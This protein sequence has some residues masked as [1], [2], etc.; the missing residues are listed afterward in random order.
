MVLVGEGP[1]KADF[2]MKVVERLESSAN[3][4][5]NKMLD[6]PRARTW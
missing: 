6:P 1:I 4:E 5:T 2:P 3:I